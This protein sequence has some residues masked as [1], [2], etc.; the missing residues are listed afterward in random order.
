M[1]KTNHIQLKGSAS[2]G[3]T[4]IYNTKI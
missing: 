4:S 1:I 2:I 3:V